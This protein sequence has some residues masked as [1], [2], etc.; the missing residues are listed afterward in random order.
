MGL[1][2]T[3]LNEWHKEHGK[4]VS[5]SGWE[6]PVKFS[7]IQDEHMTVRENV[8]LFDIS[9]MGRVLVEG[10]DATPFLEY[11]LTRDVDGLSNGKCGYSLVCNEM[12]GIKDDLVINKFSDE[13]YLVICNAVNRKKIL[14]WFIFLEEFLEFYGE[15]DLDL[16]I[17]D[18]TDS[19]ILIAVQGPKSESTLNK[20]V[21]GDLPDG[22][23]TFKTM[24]VLGHESIVSRTGYTGEDGFE[25]IPL[26]IPNEPSES[27]VELWSSI[28][29]AGEEFDI[30]PCGLG[31]RD[32]LRLE[33]GMPLYGHEL[34]E[35]ITPLEAKLTF[36][37]DLSEG[38]KFFGKAP[39]VEQKKN[40][41]ERV[42]VG[43]EVVEKGVPREGME[44]RR[45]G[46]KIGE[47]TSGTFS[48]VLKKGIGMGY[49]PFE[50]SELG[51]SLD[52]LIRGKENEIE[53]VKW[54]FYTDRG[55]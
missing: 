20:L 27:A 14:N 24:D 23:Y 44:I 16:K 45:D 12:G 11:L 41:L 32:T 51:T 52:L 54:P 1:N 35:Y 10:E 55:E 48:P 30:K 22:R 18:K 47:V 7:G 19:T 34:S 31:S 43:F 21:S 26:D 53:I 8:G 46:E 39:L 28:L 50:Y 6:L 25:I 13:K 4:V 36:V 15:V 40:D 42:R 17:E 5:F 33:A 9:H 38:K 3:A 2:T 49:V 29:E 37:V